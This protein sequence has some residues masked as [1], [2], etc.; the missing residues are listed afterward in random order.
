MQPAIKLIDMA[1]DK[2]DDSSKDI[3]NSEKSTEKLDCCLYSAPDE[4]LM[5]TIEYIPCPDFQFLVN[6]TIKFLI[7]TYHSI[8]IYLIIYCL[9]FRP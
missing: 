9:E 8:D 6:K 4:G 3:D 2:I 7:F 5:D 1:G